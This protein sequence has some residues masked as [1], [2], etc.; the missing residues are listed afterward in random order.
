[1]CWFS[2]NCTRTREN[3]LEAIVFFHDLKQ[4]ALIELSAITK[5]IYLYEPRGDLT[6]QPDYFCNIEVDIPLTRQPLSWRQNVSHNQFYAIKMKH[7]V[8]LKKQD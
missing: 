7:V 8:R 5:N 3:Q 6:F 2:V 1:M 4:R